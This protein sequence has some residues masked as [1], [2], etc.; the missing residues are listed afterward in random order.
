[1]P[2]LLSSIFNPSASS[3]HP[4]PLIPH[5]SD[6]ILPPTLYRVVRWVE[7]TPADGGPHAPVPHLPGPC[8]CGC[9]V[10]LYA[11]EYTAWVGVGSQRRC[12]TP[13]YINFAYIQGSPSGCGLD[14][15][16]GTPG[17]WRAE[18][19]EHRRSHGI[20]MSVARFTGGV[21]LL[22]LFLCQFCTARVLLKLFW[23]CGLELSLVVFRMARPQN[24]HARTHRSTVRSCP[25]TT[26]W[27]CRCYCYAVAAST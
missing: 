16:R 21:Q 25:K 4:P 10:Y 17:V 3:L 12:E 2:R 15:E 18:K 7:P 8:T 20:Y 13:V 5:P 22:L 14:L 11:P 23:R 9:D 27:N 1:M 26:I 24:T 19:G 6:S